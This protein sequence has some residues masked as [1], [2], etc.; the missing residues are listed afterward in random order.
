MLSQNRFKTSQGIDRYE[1]KQLKI[2][3]DI[4]I[5][6][7]YLDVR[8]QRFHDETFQEAV[9]ASID[10]PVFWYK[11]I[12]TPSGN[13]S[14]FGITQWSRFSTFFLCFL[15]IKPSFRMN[16]T[17]WLPQDFFQLAWPKILWSPQKAFSSIWLNKIHLELSR[18]SARVLWIIFISQFIEVFR[19]VEQ[20]SD[21][22]NTSKNSFANIGAINWSSYA[23]P[24]A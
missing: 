21:S 22:H 20:S 18:V 10:K 11:N 23:A 13:L 3:L 6:R 4:C 15:Y 17:F 12:F 16:S 19:D 8:L 14:S 9:R 24:R 1:G 5:S 2:C 7:V